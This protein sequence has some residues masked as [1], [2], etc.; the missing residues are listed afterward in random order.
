MK[1]EII[2]FAGTYEGR[3]LCE[4]LDKNIFNITV[5]V[6]SEYG[7]EMLSH[8]AGLNVLVS[9][10]T[11]T[12]M[13]SLFEGKK[14][15]IVVDATHP[16][17]KDV[18]CNIVSATTTCGVEYFR[19]LREEKVF[20]SVKSVSDIDQAVDFLETTTGNILLTTGSKELAKFTRLTGFSDR[21]YARVL[22]SAE[23]ITHCRD[24]GLSGNHILG[25]QGPFT[26]D[27]N[28]AT[29]RQLDCKF[30][31]TK[32][33]GKAGGIDEKVQS[34]IDTNATIIIID[35]PLKE[36]GYSLESAITVLNKKYI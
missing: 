27:F 36:T 11:S 8:I 14:V 21:V 22:P 18:T 7:K 3:M 24:C 26:L 29:I 28:I 10:L 2:V 31:V 20:D 9:R 13:V 25:L 15:S 23:M 35:R 32:N 12:E 16:Y 17:A 30:I 33:T 19:V 4:N 34:A 6:A 5:C 1:K